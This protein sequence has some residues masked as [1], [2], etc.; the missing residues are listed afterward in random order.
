[1][2]SVLLGPEIKLRVARIVVIASII[3]PTEAWQ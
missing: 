1:V 3:P 2:A